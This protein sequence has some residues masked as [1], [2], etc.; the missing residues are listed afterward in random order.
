[1]ATANIDY[2][3][4]KKGGPFAK[5]G[6]PFA[7]ASSLAASAVLYCHRRLKGM[8]VGECACTE[9]MLKNMA[10]N[11]TVYDEFVFNGLFSHVAFNGLLLVEEASKAQFAT[12]PSNNVKEAAALVKV[13]VQPICDSIH[14]V[15]IKHQSISIFEAIEKMNMFA[16]NVAPQLMTMVKSV[17]T[18]AGNRVF[19]KAVSAANVYSASVSALNKWA[20]RVFDAKAVEESARKE[21]AEAERQRVVAEHQYDVAEYHY[22]LTKRNLAGASKRAESAN[23]ALAAVGAGNAAIARAESAASAK[24]ALAALGTAGAQ[25]D[26]FAVQ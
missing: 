18:H 11:A 17:E 8:V 9:M 14:E 4:E 3:L 26:E 10:K 22:D 16:D 13:A 7:H 25:G 15:V 19:A 6:C 1:M 24:A 20:T 12:M 23:A 5:F 2:L 21:F